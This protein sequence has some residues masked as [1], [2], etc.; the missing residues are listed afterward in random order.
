MSNME[1][2]RGT[3]VTKKV[4]WGSIAGGVLT[5][6]SITLLLSIFGASLGLAI[7]DPLGGNADNGASMTMLFWTGGSIAVSLAAG[8]FVAGRLAAA[9]GFI[10]GFLVWASSL[11]IA[12]ILGVM[13]VGAVVKATGSA[14]GSLASASGSLLSGAGS[15]AGSGIQGAG[16]IVDKIFD[17]LDMDSSVEPQKLQANV[18]EALRKSKIPSLQ[19]DFV[20]QQLNGAKEDI[21]SAVQQ[22]TTQPVDSDVIIQDV[23][24]KLKERGKSITKDVD[25]STLTKAISENSDMT[26]GEVNKAVDNIIEAKESADN[27]LNQKFDDVQ[28]KIEGA[29][30][31]YA[32]FKNKAREQAAAAA[33]ALAKSALWTFIALVTGAIISGLTGRIG[34]KSSRKHA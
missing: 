7:V 16:D 18:K 26:Q 31:Q 13:L 29:K 4:S 12:C 11:I 21:A 3:A 23:M 14:I 9:D 20:Q 5:V 32:E 33:A 24:D 28:K 19:P 8:A 27:L 6:I 34:A 25:R 10:H 15:V 1:L 17:G 2:T 22:L 30:Q